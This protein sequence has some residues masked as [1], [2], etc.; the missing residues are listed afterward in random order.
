MWAE[1]SLTLL[2]GCGAERDRL[3]LFK[4]FRQLCEGVEKRERLTRRL[5]H[6]LRREGER[7]RGK[8]GR[9]EKGKE[10]GRERGGGRTE[11][12]GRMRK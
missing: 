8:E 10:E 2:H 4:H 9:K 12:G 5:V 7:E 1:C 3:P 6:I 11:G